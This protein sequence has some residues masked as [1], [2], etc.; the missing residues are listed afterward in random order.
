[1]HG[2]IPAAIE[3]RRDKMGFV[4]PEELWLK[5]EGKQWF[6]DAIDYT[7]KQFPNIIDEPKLKQHVDEIISGKRK[8]TF[9][10]WRVAALGIWHKRMVG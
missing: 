6:L 9:V 5:G 7:C 2:I 10:P 3:G 1:M 4:T 8:F